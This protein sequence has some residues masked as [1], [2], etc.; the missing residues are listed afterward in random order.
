VYDQRVRVVAALGADPA[1]DRRG[2]RAAERA[3]RDHLHH[4]E[5]REDE[6]HPGQRVGAELGDPP[7]L[8]DSGHRLPEHDQHVRPGHPQQQRNDRCLQQ[9]AGPRT[10]FRARRRLRLHAEHLAKPGAA[11]GERLFASGRAPFR[12][13][14][15]LLVSP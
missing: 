13:E 4:H 3:G 12:A 9:G 8:D 5:A 7:R 15:G 14:Q 2:D 6:R 1:G 10:Q 11:K